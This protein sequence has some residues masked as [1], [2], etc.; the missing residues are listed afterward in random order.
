MVTSD[1]IRKKV[2]FAAKKNHNK[3]GWFTS[4]SGVPAR[5]S[6]TTSVETWT[7]VASTNVRTWVH[8]QQQ[9]RPLAE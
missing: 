4:R 6:A 8:P 2:L 5:N 3:Y 9:K 1:L 7:L